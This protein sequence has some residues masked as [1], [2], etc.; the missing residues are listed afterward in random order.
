M[1]GTCITQFD[2][3]LAYVCSLYTYDQHHAASNSSVGM[4][5]RVEPWYHSGA[6]RSGLTRPAL[7]EHI[8]SLIRQKCQ[9]YADAEGA[10]D[11]VQM[12]DKR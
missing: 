3:C 6:E 10:S 2:I 8:S 9:P 7:D 5:S 11:Q 12:N 1:R 4:D